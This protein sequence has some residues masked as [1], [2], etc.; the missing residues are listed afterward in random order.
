MVEIGN[1]YGSG[2]NSSRKA[3]T[4][5]EFAMWQGGLTAEEVLADYNGVIPEPATIGLLAAGLVGLIRR[6]RA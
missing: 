3:I 1:D 5:D 2:N 4:F 6:R